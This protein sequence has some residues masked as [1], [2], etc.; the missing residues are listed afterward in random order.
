M[1]VVLTGND[2]AL[3][4]SSIYGTKDAADALRDA[5]AEAKVV[6]GEH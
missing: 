6:V 2:L 4:L 5:A 3:D 1:T